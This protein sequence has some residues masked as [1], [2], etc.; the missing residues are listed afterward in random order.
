MRAGVVAEEVG[1][2]ISR[3]WWRALHSPASIYGILIGAS[4][5]AASDDDEPVAEVAVAVLVTLLIYWAAERWSNVL[6]AQLRERPLSR[7][8]TFR[9]FAAGWPM[10]Q[11]SY[12][13]L[14]I[15]VVARFFGAS[16][17][18]AVGLA[19]VTNV[20]LL[21]MLGALAGR[22][23]GLAGWT[24]VLSAGFTGALGLLLIVLK[25]VLH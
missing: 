18:L 25:A 7:T 20:V 2:A 19:L 8:E 15:M 16:N 11:A 5:M 23:A 24:V 9:I 1:A 4:V 17:D 3:R 14:L 22:R 10:V 6:G 12:A 13:P 21:T